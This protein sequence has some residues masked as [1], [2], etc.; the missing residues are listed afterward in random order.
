MKR[1]IFLLA[2]AA[3]PAF[4]QT[5]YVR[6]WLI[7]G[8]FPHADATTRLFF[9]FLGGEA[10]VKPRGG[11]TIA[12]RAWL[13]YHSPREFID[14]RWSDLP[15]SARERC[16]VY[17]ALFVQSPREQKVRLMVGSDDGIT[18]WCNGQTVHQN[19]VYRGVV[20]DNDTVLVAL[21]SGWNTI[22][23]KVVN[24]DGGYGLSARFADGEGLVLSAEN[25][26]T[27][28]R[29]L[30]P[31]SLS[32]PSPKLN[33]NFELNV[34]Q[35]L[36][37]SYD[38]PLFNSGSTAAE[39]IT[40]ELS[41]GDKTIASAILPRVMGGELIRFQQRLSF[42]D[43]VQVSD[44]KG[45]SRVRLRYDGK[46][47]SR[48]FEFTGEILRRFFEAWQLQGWQ[49]DRM[50][51]SSVRYTRT[52][53]V[54]DDL[55][56][57]GLQIAVDIWDRWGDVSVNGT[58]KLARFSGDS[59]ELLLTEK[60]A[61]RDTFRIELT[62][63]SE[64]PIQGS[65][66]VSSTI[67]PRH[68]VIERYL[69][70]VR[71]AKEIYN[72]D[73][74]DQ[75]AAAT[76][77]L[78]LL[79]AR[80]PDRAAEILRPLNQ[81]IAS[82][83]PEAKKLSLHLIGHAHIDMAWLWR[84]AETMEVTRATFQ[85][86]LDN[87]KM[88]PDFHFS[89]G[90]AQSYRWIEDQHPEMFEEIQQYVKAGRWEIVGGTWVEPDANMP[91]GESLVRQYL[92]GKRYFKEKFGVT[93]KHGFFP[94]T[95]GHPATL[96]Q[97]MAKSGIETYT[98]FRP[99]EDER[100]FWWESP[101][102][103]RVFA[104]RPAN[105]YGTWSGIPDTL[106]KAA[107]N[108]QRSFAV[109]DAVQFFGVGDH[110]GGPT[111]RQIEQIDQLS[112][113]TLY[114]DTRMSTFTEF[115]SK[116]VPQKGNAPVQRGEQNPVFEGCYTSQ[117]K[118]KLLNRKAEAL[119]P[120]AELFSS[121]AMR[122]GFDYP[123]LELREAWN[124]VLFNQFHDILCGSSI[125]EVYFDSEQYYQEAF[126]R[127]ET[128]LTGALRTLASSIATLHRSKQAVPVVVF[129]PLNWN[130]TGPIETAWK[131]VGAAVPQI[132]DEKGRKVPA[133]VTYRSA[134]SLRLLFVP[135]DVPSVG[136]RTF[137]ITAGKEKKATP[138]DELLVLENRYFRVEVD[139]SSGCVSRLLDKTRKRE[140]LRDGAL[141]NQLQIQEDAA[142][143]SAWVIG[144]RGEPK[145]I[146]PPSSVKVLESGPVRKVV[147]SEYL[148]EQSAFFM[149]VILYE[150][151]PRI[152]FRF[153]ADWHH[154]QRIL[155]VAFPLNVTDGKATFEI[156]YGALQRQANGHEVVAQKWVDLS[157]GDFGVSLLND[158]RYGFDVRGS[159][160]RMTLLR[161]S[162]DPDPK[163]DE[164]RHEFS[165]SLY[166][167][168]GGWE[169]AGTVL[170]GYEFNTPMVAIPTDQH[171]GQY[172]P[173][174]A[175]FTI[176]P[177]T[178]VLTALKKCEDDG[179]LILRVYETTGKPTQA[180]ILFPH[181]VVSAA[182]TD[183]IEW[184]ERRFVTEGL[185]EG[186]IQLSL[187][188]FEIRTLK[189]RLGSEQ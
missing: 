54:P 39:R 97:I 72:I 158:S 100:M 166:P 49:E 14:F 23:M 27:P 67:R 90:Q 38:L 7:L 10:T 18:I 138:T 163:A 114:P 86:A 172:R 120:T 151:L 125:H 176:K 136:Y 137:W 91:S 83:A 189:L 109:N 37:F 105:W 126:E 58:K 148:Y 63:T 50:G 6:D 28:D 24:G 115:Y 79:N 124:R 69:K 130:R 43:A 171:H 40:V 36:I 154:R 77:L 16:A 135:N 184:D 53:I 101:D 60:A 33:F 165:Y 4:A 134:D 186:A 104:Y 103:S 82:F 25:P 64:K 47:T 80:K 32:C 182:E 123:G 168:G 93:V 96:P 46:E 44:R 122:F 185:K 45:L 22:L 55:E 68:G 11:E 127:A 160:L 66:L 128:A 99:W 51:E 145:V 78:G 88:Y 110:G 170:R 152:D 174:H 89:H 156:P 180:Q 146:G 161:S 162:T 175:F 85:A 178:V 59:G 30:T 133:Q 13:L 107:V 108:T 111:R 29:P 153:S 34:S 73:L 15:F 183:L 187:K 8:S 56:G 143:M 17:A 26:F 12:G 159:D 57:L 144:L 117:A 94:D 112:K 169:A 173:S 119:L 48:A 164:G 95:F 35:Q 2:F 179:S 142:P 84:V 42:R 140:V 132:V 19:D 181:P 3:S 52:V 118:T 62:A 121:L 106:W 76:Q 149:D 9:D 116:L 70:D 129:N 102:G 150:E 188:P 167:H 92:Y 1:L 65:A 157:S 131:S 177:S 21:K 155:K 141:G 31:A 81:K 147:R 20:L 41:V 71:F 74:G 139:R 98:F 75:T 61:A 87:L 113:V 5:D